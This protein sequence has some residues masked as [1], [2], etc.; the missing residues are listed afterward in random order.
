MTLLINSLVKKNIKPEEVKTT[1]DSI[2]VNQ[3]KATDDITAI[4]SRLGA[5]REDRSISDSIAIIKKSVDDIKTVT[6]V[7]EEDFPK[8]TSRLDKVKIPHDS[9]DVKNLV[10]VI[11]RELDEYFA[12]FTSQTQIL[13]ANGLYRFTIVSEYQ[14]N[15]TALIDVDGKNVTVGKGINTVSAFINN[16]LEIKAITFKITAVEATVVRASIRWYLEFITEI[17]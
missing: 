11:R 15:I 3:Q 16:S 2:T 8:I 9:S 13:D 4:N 10:Y 12:P 5:V 6:D 17:N 14:F 7:V 1:I